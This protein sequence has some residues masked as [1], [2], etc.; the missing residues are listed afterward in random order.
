[1]QLDYRYPTEIQTL[2]ITVIVLLAALALTTPFTVGVTA[3]L[4][5]VGFALNYLFVRTQIEGLKRRA[6]RVTATQFP[7]IKALVDECA[8][9]V[10]VPADTEVYIKY[11]P[12]MNALAMGVGKPYSI[13]LH[14][15]LVESLDPD[16]LKSV[17]GHEMGHIKFGHTTLLTLVGQLGSQTFGIPLVGDLIRYVFLFWSRSAEFTA[18]R[19]GL[20]AVGR[21]D[22]AVATEVKLAVGPELAKRVDMRELARQA[23]ESRGN[24]LGT[25]GEMDGTHPMMTSRI[26]KM[27]DFAASET[28]G[29][30]RPDM[31]GIN[32]QEARAW[33]PAVPIY[34]AGNTACP[35]CGKLTTS[36]MATFCMHCGAKLGQPGQCPQCQT[37]LEPA[38]KVCPRC[39]MRL[40]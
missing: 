5:V 21:L 38:W 34:A 8:H 39:G 32:F 29:R 23:R 27:V 24:L 22:R 31:R 16:E 13:V 14:S 25:L 9:R 37:A 36:P 33:Q 10:G 15:A 30:L 12:V 4:F 6:V 2:V 40:A 17:I 28:F 19:A 11:S 35:A 18:D 1:M 7:E 3:I 20:V 26:Q